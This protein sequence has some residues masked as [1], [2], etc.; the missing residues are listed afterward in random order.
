M[1]VRSQS[2][3]SSRFTHV[4]SLAMIAAIG[5][6]ALL[7]AAPSPNF[8][9]IMADD[10]SHDTVENAAEEAGNTSWLA[11]VGFL[12]EVDEQRSNRVTEIWLI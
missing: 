10:E 6:P 9:V 12:V 5:M 3:R 4:V 11:R 8:I 7:H 2:I 1:K